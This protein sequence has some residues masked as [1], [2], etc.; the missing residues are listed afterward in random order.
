MKQSEKMTK[1]KNKSTYGLGSMPYLGPLFKSAL[2]SMGW[3]LEIA[4]KKT[5]IYYV[6]Y[7]VSP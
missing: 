3:L 6:F 4:K 2:R 5:S 7:S 1:K